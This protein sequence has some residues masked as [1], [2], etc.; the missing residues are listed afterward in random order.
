MVS[1]VSSL[2]FLPR[3]PALDVTNMACVLQESIFFLCYFKNLTW[4]RIVT[5][6]HLTKSRLWSET[7]LHLNPSLVVKLWA[8]YFTSLNFS[9]VTCTLVPD[10]L[11]PRL[12]G[13][14]Y[15]CY[16]KYLWRAS[17]TYRLLTEYYQFC[18]CRKGR[19]Y[20]SSMELSSRAG[21]SKHFSMVFTKGH[22]W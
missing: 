11:G 22:T 9:I 13:Y 7:V 21:V 20:R 8:S 16:I 12:D 15:R 4:N 2:P 3:A 17:S 14:T 1:I 6:C 18:C 5:S 19:L 10:H